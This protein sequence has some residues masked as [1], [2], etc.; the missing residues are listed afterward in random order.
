MTAPIILYGATYSVYSRI[1]RLV[2]EE[3]RLP[4]QFEEI[5]IFAEGGP[6]ASYR[7][8][9]PFGKIP[10]LDHGDLTIIETHVICEY[11]EDAFPQPALLPEE[12]GARAKARQIIGMLDSYAYH[13]WVWDIFVESV[14]K[15]RNGGTSDKAKIAEALPLAEKCA[16]FIAQMMGNAPYIAGT[17]GPTMADFHA[18]PMMTYLSQA[19]EGRYLLRRHARLGEWL[20]R[21]KARSSIA[22]TVSPLEN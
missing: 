4:Y 10:A 22:K 7:K 20:E 19:E 14:G 18:Y 9:H 5:D 11:L 16:S 17:T 12:P 8:K 1:A 6:T 15:P 13:C 3:K 2:L 21:M